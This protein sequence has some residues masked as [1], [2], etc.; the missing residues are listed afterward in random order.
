M[1]GR[2]TT[3]EYQIC[4][5]AAADRKITRLTTIKTE[6]IAFYHVLLLLLFNR[7]CL[8]VLLGKRFIKECREPF[9]SL[10]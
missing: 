10:R 7:A 6:A 9:A 4:F 3:E 1:C 8:M 2:F 5:W